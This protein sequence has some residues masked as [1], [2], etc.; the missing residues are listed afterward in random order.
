MVDTFSEENQNKIKLLA[1]EVRLKYGAMIWGISPRQ[2]IECEG[3]KYDEYDLQEKGF[4]KYVTKTI[5]KVVDRIKAAL[6]VREKHVLI[7]HSLHYAKRPFGQAHEL[8][9]HVISHHRKI[10]YV[11]SEHDLHPEVRGKMEFEANIFASEILYP[12]PLL[13]NIYTKYP[14]CME[15]ILQ[16]RQLSNGSYHSSAIKYVQESDKV[17]CLQILEIDSDDDGN[18]G[19][20]LKKQIFSTPWREKHGQLLDSD[21]FFSK[22]HVLSQVVFSATAEDIVK[23]IIN[24][25]GTEKNFYVHTFY[26]QF[27]VL[28]LLFE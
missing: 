22:N 12:G 14:L 13:E 7:D 5:K 1:Q 2:L 21:Q 20:R 8:G 23:E 4:I 6:I 28:A 3:L 15:T 24:V 25:R 18:R 27:V 10:L 17:C 26:N 16:L 11:C 19:L 9:H